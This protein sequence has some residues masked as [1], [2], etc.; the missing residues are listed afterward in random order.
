MPDDGELPPSDTYFTAQPHSRSQRRRL[1]FLYRG[2]VI[3]VEVDR[4]VFASAGLDRGTGLLI[5]STTVGSSDRVLDIGCGWG[6]VGIAA[7]KSAHSGR[8]VLVDVNRRAVHLAR[9]N[10]ERN[11]IENAEVRMGSLFEPVD[12]ERFDLIITNPPYRAG[13]PL[14]ERLI[15]EAPAHLDPGGRL[16]LVGKKSQGIKF[17]QDLLESKWPG[18]VEVLSR[19]SGYRVLEAR[20]ALPGRRREGSSDSSPSKPVHREMSMLSSGTSRPG[21][22]GP[23]D[24]PNRRTLSLRAI[25]ID[26]ARG[27]RSALRSRRSA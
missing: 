11:R 16:V 9:R 14:I 2:E 23:C 8:V 18:L 15:R 24:L 5:E 17:Y 26:D 25:S 20:L 7:A 19:G 27:S 21:G 6:A 3:E 4:G 10:L 12:G 1:R 13:R 22:T